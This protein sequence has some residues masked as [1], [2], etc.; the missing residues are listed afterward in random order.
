VLAAGGSTRLG[1]PKQ[2]VRYQGSTLLAR[3]VSAA[4][5]AG[6]TPVLAIIGANAPRMRKELHGLAIEV[7]ENVKWREGM[8]T[9]IRATLDALAGREVDAL[10][11]LTCDQPHVTEG[12]LRTLVD[13]M[14]SSGCPA[15]ACSYAGGVGVPALFGRELHGEL[16]ALVAD[17]GA[18]AILERH[19]DRIAVVPFPLGAV[20]VDSAE[21]LDTLR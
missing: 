14:R 21:D 9:S 3:A 18:H 12:L 19:R 4:V 17:R 5:A 1:Q 10:L 20:D 6:C 15:V 7:V 13:T 8:S 11:F 16:R 2:L